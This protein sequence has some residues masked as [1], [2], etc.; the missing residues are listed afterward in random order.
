MAEVIDIVDDEDFLSN[1]E[2]AEA[3]AKRR[4]LEAAAENREGS[5]MA[6][7][8]GSKS[9]LWQRQ[10]TALN[11]PPSTR[12]NPKGRVATAAAAADNYS[13]T[14]DAGACFKCGKSGHWARD[15]VGSS[16][17]AVG[18]DGGLVNHMVAEKP[19]PCGSGSCL[20]LTAN[21][22]KNRGRKFYRCPVREENGGCGFFEWCDNSSGIPS[23]VGGPNNPSNSLVPDLLCPCG[24]GTCLVLTAKT[25]KNM[26]QQFYRCPANQGGSCGFFKWC[27]DHNSPVAGRLAS[28]PRVYSTWNDTSSQPPIGRSGSSC[29]KCGQEGHWARDCPKPSTDT[30]DASGRSASSNACYKCGKSGHWAKDCPSQD[31]NVTTGSRKASVPFRSSHGYTSK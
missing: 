5:Y 7:L 18:G 28:A 24:A 25:E 27:S 23:S 15:C 31:T 29:F 12:S 16:G 22:E 26:G 1:V 3:I 21:T 19:C 17:G 30:V 9:L 13:G 8:K 10:Q 11:T 2:A 4:K 14:A 20:V 6:A